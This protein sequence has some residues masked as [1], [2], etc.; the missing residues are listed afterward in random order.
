MEIFS[1]KTKDFIQ[2]ISDKVWEIDRKNYKIEDFCGNFQ[3]HNGMHTNTIR[4]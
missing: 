3:R 4:M 1:D 2:H